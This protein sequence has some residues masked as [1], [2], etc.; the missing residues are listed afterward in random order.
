MNTQTPK[1]ER[2]FDGLNRAW[3]TYVTNKLIYAC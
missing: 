2:A 1:K 3:A